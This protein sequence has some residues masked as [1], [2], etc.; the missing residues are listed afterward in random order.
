MKFEHVKSTLSAARTSELMVS[1]CAKLMKSRYLMS[2]RSPC[3]MGAPC[4]LSR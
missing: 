2:R 3:I 1:C 4:K